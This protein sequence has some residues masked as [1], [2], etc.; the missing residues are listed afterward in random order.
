MSS[1]IETGDRPVMDYELVAIAKALKI[2]SAQL[3][4]SSQ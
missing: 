4:S 2:P 3:L 1:R